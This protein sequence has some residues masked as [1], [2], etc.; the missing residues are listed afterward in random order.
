[1]IALVVG[2]FAL[3]MLLVIKGACIV[4]LYERNPLKD[5]IY[6]CDN[7]ISLLFKNGANILSVWYYIIDPEMAF[8]PLYLGGL[9]VVYG[10][11]LFMFRWQQIGFYDK[12]YMNFILCL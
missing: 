10:W 12:K 1:M 4:L 7:N 5:S 11:Y 9:V 8:K 3:T 6:A 2:L